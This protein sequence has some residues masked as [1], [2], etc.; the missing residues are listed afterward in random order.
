MLVLN[1]VPVIS[2]IFGYS[3]TVIATSSTLI[4]ARPVQRIIISEPILSHHPSKRKLLAGQE[5]QFGHIIHISSLPFP[6]C[7]HTPTLQMA[8]SMAMRRL[9]SASAVSTALLP[10]SESLRPFAMPRL[11]FVGVWGK[12]HLLIHFLAYSSLVP[13]DVRRGH[14][15]RRARFV[16]SAP[17]S[18]RPQIL[19]AI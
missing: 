1:C 14:S 18:R 9:A 17:R 7:L 8:S 5:P 13:P 12:C 3:R 16:R 6:S 15:P 11:C 10:S 2:P 4:G 19:A